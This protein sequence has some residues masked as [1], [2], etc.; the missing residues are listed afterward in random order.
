VAVLA[1]SPLLERERQLQR[2][3][4]VFDD[5]ARGQGA[6]LFV[7]GEAGVGK[8][9]LVTTLRDSLRDRARTLEGACDSL[10]T[11]RPLAPIADLAL[12]TGGRLADVVERGGR[13]YE[14]LPAFLAELGA[15]PTLVVL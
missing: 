13:A 7:A 1:R 14:V 2:L 4:E 10:F 3:Q 15:E 6:L 11:P 8:T 12:A 5:A 9:A